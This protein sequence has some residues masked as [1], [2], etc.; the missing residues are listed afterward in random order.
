MVKARALD[1][2]TALRFTV[3]TIVRAA[4][5]LRLSQ[6]TRFYLRR[7][8]AQSPQSPAGTRGSSMQSCVV[9]AGRLASSVDDR[10][11]AWNGPSSNRQHAHLSSEPG[12]DH[13]AFRRET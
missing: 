5:Q 4:C 3:S 1:L 13:R 7:P 9:M 8:A 6:P 12:R 11:A 2:D 10:E